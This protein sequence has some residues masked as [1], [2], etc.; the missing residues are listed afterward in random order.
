MWTK[1]ILSLLCFKLHKPY[2]LLVIHVEFIEGC[3]DKKWKVFLLYLSSLSHL[4]EVTSI[5][6]L[7]YI[8]VHLLPYIANFP[9]THP[10]PIAMDSFLSLFLLLPSH[11]YVIYETHTCHFFYRKCPIIIIWQLAF[12]SFCVSSLNLI[13]FN[14]CIIFSL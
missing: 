11:I 7:V 2:M 14:D 10:L 12:L 1:D 4:A 3:K 9:V 13:V 5:S 8:L 6:N